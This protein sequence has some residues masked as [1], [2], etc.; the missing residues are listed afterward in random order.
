MKIYQKNKTKKKTLIRFVLTYVYFL[1]FKQ[2]F[3]C[4]TIEMLVLHFR[5]RYVHYGVRLYEI[6]NRYLFYLL[7]D[8]K[9][10]MEV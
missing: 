2:L 8:D 7:T 5:E 4:K 10:K 6:L 3:F 9:N 1:L